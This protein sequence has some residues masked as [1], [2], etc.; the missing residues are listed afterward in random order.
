MRKLFTKLFAVMFVLLLGTVSVSAAGTT[1][2]PI[3]AAEEF[4]CSN[5]NITAANWVTYT[6]ASYT[7]RSNT[8]DNGSFPNLS[9]SNRA[10]VFY[11]SG[12]A[13]FTITTDGNS[14]ARYLTYQIN[15]GTAVQTAAWP[16]GCS[17]Q[18]FNTG[19][20]GAITITIAGVSGSVYLGTVKFMPPATPTITAF[21]AGGVSATINETAKTISAVLPFGTD[22]AAITPTVTIGGP[23]IG[24]SPSGAQNFTNSATTPVNYTATDGTTNV[25]YAVSLTASTVANSDA[26][27]SDLKV[28]GTTITGFSAATLTYNVALPYV[29][30]GIPVISS[31]VNA[32]TSSQVIAQASAIPGSA[33]VTVTAQDNSQKVYTINFTRTPV[34]TGND[35][36]SFSINGRVGVITDQ[37]ILV[38]MHLTTNVTSLTPNV[39]VSSLATYTP[40][41]AQDFTNPVN[42]IVTAQDGTQKTYTVT[43]QLADLNYTG[44]YPYITNFP[45]GYV[46]PVWMGSPTSGIVFTD[47]YTGSDKALWYDNTTESTAGTTSVIRFNTNTAMDILVSQCGTVTAKVSATGGR[48]YN[49]YINGVSANSATVSS[50]TMATLTASPNLSVPTTIRIENPS[51]SG[52]ITLGYLEI[53]APVGTGISQT[54]IAGVTFD[55]KVIHN[56]PNLDLLVFEATGRLVASSN[57]DIDM[58][59]KA[60][61]IYL[62]KSNIGALKIVI[63]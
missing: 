26:T 58:S 63:R 62:V 19:N 54:Q 8:C 49:L 14:S 31:T 34:S 22:L 38:Q 3:T 39:V 40:S 7:S 37:T 23:A 33:T 11:V 9:A 12:C 47:P 59:S 13:S 56:T 51:T 15:T 18:T 6:A 61:G 1:T 41:G 5:A 45:S 36:T 44:P 50:N 35:I 32:P 48:T 16:A 46:I 60:K 21:T 30:S 57:K 4:S 43:V 53:D 55:G 17:A 28:D 42:Y 20:T 29:Y 2:H 27:L 25:V 24:Y 10:V 52:G